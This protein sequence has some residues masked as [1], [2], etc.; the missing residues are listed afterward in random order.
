MPLD[1]EKAARNWER[2]TYCRD[3]GHLD[4][5]H[6][7]EKCDRFFEGIQW[8]PMVLA[9]LREARRPGLTINK[10]LGT[11]SSI[12]GEQIDLRTEIA[13]KGRYGAPSDGAD[14]LTKLAKFISDQNQLDWLR[15]E[16]FA[17]GAI[18]SR[19]FLDM[20]ISY[21]HCVTGDVV[22]SILNPK[23]VIPDPDAEEYDP[24]TWADVIVTKWMSC[25]E[26]EILY[27]KKDAE[28]LR[29]R[30]DGSWAY[31]YDSIEQFRDRFG[32]RNPQL[33]DYP[34]GR[35]VA[36]M[37]RVIDRQ[38]KKLAKIRY[39]V[40]V[41]TGDRQEIPFD[42]KDDRVA[43]ELS[44][45]RGRLILDEHIGQ[46]IRWLVTADDVVLKD[47]WSPYKHFTVIPY[48]PYFRHGTTIGLVEN[49]I[50]IQELLNK[51]TSQEL[52][53]VNT[54]ANSGWKVRQGALSNM[55]PDELEMYGAKSGLV[56][57]VNGDPDKDIVKITPNQIP[58]GL[59]RLS[60]KAENYIKSVSMRGDAQMGMTRADVSADQI[61]ANNAFGDV[62]LRKPLD[63]LLRT[64]HIIGR[65]LRDLIQ[66]FYTDPRIATITKSELLGEQE[67]F[68]INWPDPNTGELINDVTMG[69]YDVTI[70]S[71]PSK[72]TLE[73]SQFEQ[74]V[75][76]REKLGIPIP[77]EFFIQ[78]SNVLDKSRLARALKAQA[79]SPE[80]QEAKK[81]AALSQQLQVADMKSKV[82][83]QEA[84]ALKKRAAAGKEVAQTQEIM[85][86]EP[87]AQAEI[88][89]K[90][91]ESE[92]EMALDLQKHQQEMQMEREKFQLK[93]EL[94]RRQG[95]EKIRLQRAQAI[96]TMKQAAQQNKPGQGAAGQK[97]KPQ[98][99]KPA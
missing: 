45:A 88:E 19:G 34:E 47:E 51:T 22:F 40:D 52:H 77:D 87:G 81:A 28:L 16:M 94:E 15:S 64:N 61:E 3:T 56:L 95:E 70:I 4:Y 8:D 35:H 46:R 93:M 20:R 96:L 12:M 69:D 33:V 42:W 85:N 86:G 27:N 90:R 14:T 10:I 66:E 80:A 78:N 74:L 37:I 89:Q 17:D 55:T 58:Q 50:D 43:E 59:D 76:L 23:N 63:N 44:K 97:A 36:R 83:S 2:Y 38:Y 99:A 67:T 11:I 21:D 73:M 49:L 72:Q 57:E 92:Q 24:D 91:I 84:D 53:V 9:D 5:V 18:T 68:Y 65:N 79:E 7:A 82:E 98:G 60:M 1:A 32:G 62:G 30:A 48:F 54:M 13:Y 29:N 41:K 6:K 75:M 39:F 26:I 31:G 25:D 71:Q